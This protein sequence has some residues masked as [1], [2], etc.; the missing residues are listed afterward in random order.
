MR[1][2]FSFICSS[3]VNFLGQ[4]VDE[5]HRLKNKDSKLFSSLT[6]YSSN[7]RILLTGTP[8]QVCHWIGSPLIHVAK[9]L[10]WLMIMWCLFRTTWMNFSCSCIF[11]TRGRYSLRI[12]R[13]KI[14]LIYLQNI[15]YLIALLYLQFGSLEEFQEEFKDI[16]QEEQISRL[17]RMLAPHLLRSTYPK[18]SFRIV[19][20]VTVL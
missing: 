2:Y 12:N 11:L 14:S 17:H 15:M 5:G 16:N 4:I 3:S 20:K 8:L 19:D 7:H 13:D 6:Q 1:H 18:Q 10:M 9:I